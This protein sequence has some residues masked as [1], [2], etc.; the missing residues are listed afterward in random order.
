MVKT[1]R[2][3]LPIFEVIQGGVAQINFD[4]TFDLITSFFHVLCHMCESDLELFFRN[5]SKSLTQGGLLC[6]DVIKQFEVGEHGY[7]EGERLSGM[8]YL[9]YHSLRDDGAKILDAYG[10]PC[11]GTDRMFTSDEI[12]NFAKEAGLR[13]VNIEEV[14]I[15]NPDP[16]V[17]HL[18]EFAVVLCK[19]V[20]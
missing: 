17:G 9:A 14:L 20:K 3:N 12:L 10:N 7:T 19:D 13:M 2:R 8:K 5:V 11:I 4:H 1:A 16:K 18:K 15:A 6:F